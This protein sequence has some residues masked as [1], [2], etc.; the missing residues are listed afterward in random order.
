MKKKKILIILV[1]ICISILYFMQCFKVNKAYPAP[2][3]VNV[4]KG[5]SVDINGLSYKVLGH[6]L[7]DM[8]DFKKHIPTY[9]KYDD[10]FSLKCDYNILI[11]DLEVKN[12]TKNNYSFQI[13]DICIESCGFT[14]GV[15]DDYEF[16]KEE[17]N[18]K[19]F[20]IKPGE[21]VKVKLTYSLA[22]K[23]FNKSIW[24]NI[25]NTKFVLVPSLYPKNVRMEI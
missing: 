8:E 9:A 10:V 14:N 6:D 24:E 7:K 12:N 18:Q 21:S 25:E 19:S 11:V 23:M 3:I 20:D 15:S 4:K 5:D 1:L 22:E 17:D 16:E 13:Y 2:E